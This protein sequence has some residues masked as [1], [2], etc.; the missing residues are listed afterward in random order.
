MP[1]EYDNIDT[2]GTT[3][4][5]SFI[6]TDKVMN[7]Y[8]HNREV[9]SVLELLTKSKLKDLHNVID[10]GCSIGT[11]YHDFK[12][13]GFQKIIGIDISKERALKA[14]E[15][16]YDEIHVC[17]AYDL[18]FEDESQNCVISSDV[19]IHV[20]QDDDKLK[21][22]KEVYRV[23]K[24]D[25]IF[26]FN[27]ANAKGFGYD[28]TQTI[29]YCRYCTLENI[30]NLIDQTKF[31]TESILPSYYTIPR[32]AAHPYFVSISSKIIFPNIDK[33]LIKFNNSSAAKVI[34]FALRK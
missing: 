17:N 27:F 5:I 20:L 16:G 13:F 30:Q 14:K 31:K 6:K 4:E 1:T 12:I 34:Y 19:F 21:I 26:I 28:D 29:D 25:G 7:S 32:I 3:H 2:I 24:K 9:S 11:W 22:L 33:I 18:P 10:L 15:R 8:Y 23:L